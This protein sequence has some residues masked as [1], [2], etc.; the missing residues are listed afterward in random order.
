MTRDL[1]DLRNLF[2]YPVLARSERIA[3]GVVH[4][5]GVAF[6]LGGAGL[7]IL[8]A[9]RTGIGP[10][11]GPADG[12]MASGAMAGSAP[13]GGAMAGGAGL[14]AVAVYAAALVATFTASAFYH[15]APSRRLRPLLRRI[16]HAAIYLKIAG[17][18]TPLV[19]MIGSG[20]AYGVLAL[21]WVLALAGAGARLVLTQ[22]PGRLGP[23][24]Y[25]ALGW[26]SVALVWSLAQTLPATGTALVVA[27]GLLY[28]AGV[29]FFVWEGLRFATA[30]WHGFVLAASACFFGAIFLGV[31]AQA[32]G[33]A[34]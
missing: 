18:Y 1:S 17:T 7:L 33:I 34:P 28:S 12:A 21:V 19:V 13:A 14:A 31:V 24:L 23:A 10:G 3:D 15:L 11:Q 20:F 30:I 27:G 5:L 8:V 16:D 32:Q 26:L 4:A 9:A 2:D 6:A 29:V 25:L 22:P